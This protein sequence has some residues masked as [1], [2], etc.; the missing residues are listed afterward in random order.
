MPQKPKKVQVYLPS[1]RKAKRLLTH[2]QSSD[3]QLPETEEAI[4]LGIQRAEKKG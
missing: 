1:I 2:L 4:R 3:A